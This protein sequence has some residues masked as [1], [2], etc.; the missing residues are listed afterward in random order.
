[1]ISKIIDEELIQQTKEEIHNATNVVIVSHVSPD[2][3]AIGSSLGLAQFLKMMEKNVTV[4]MPNPFP[5]FLKWMPGCEEILLY[6]EKKAQA[7]KV[8][9][10]ADLIF[11]LDFN[12]LS[13]IGEMGTV[14]ADAKAR[15]V[16]IDHHLNPGGFADVVISYPKMASTSEMIFRVICRMGYFTEM[17]K[18]CAECVYTGMM[19]DT[20]GFAFNSNNSEMYVIV[21]E[22]IKK[23][24]DKDAIY[25]KIYN[26]YSADRFRLLGHI[27]SENF[28]VY[29]EIGTAVLT[30]S[31]AEL[32]KY[33]FKKGDSEGFVNIP[34]SIKGIVFSAFFK[35]DAGMI[36]VS[37]RSHGS[38]PTNQ[39]SE[40]VFGGGGHLNASG[41]E[42]YLTM[43]E[44]L[45]KFEAALPAYKDLLVAEMK[46]AEGNA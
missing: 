26:N 16:M 37:L 6:S 18:E 23:G 39:F 28:K 19:T 30:L 22:L 46:K 3:D 24:I 27:L 33:N 44:T 42:S 20:G 45:A 29:P 32:K 14:V 7:D 17:T 25:R 13:R 5:D 4:I 40:Q 41:G 8:I 10:E 31:S 35:Q 1:M 12:T 36:K 43:E 38:F 34:L 2:G 21:S 15:I 11:A 9:G